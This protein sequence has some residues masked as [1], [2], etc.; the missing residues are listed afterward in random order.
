MAV[1]STVEARYV[2][3]TSAYVRGLQQ[4]TQAT[5]KLASEIPKIEKAN[6]GATVSGLALGAAIGTLGAQV[7]AKATGA[8]MKYAQQGIAAAKQYEQTVISIEGIFAGTGMAMEEAATK[9]QSYLGELRDF[10]AKTPFE[11]PQ[12]LDAVKRLLSIG[13]AADDVKDRMLPAI[14]DIVAALGQPPSAISQIVYAFGQMKSAGRVMSQDL[15]QLGTALPGFNAKMALATEL[16]DGDMQALTKA[17]ESGALDSGKAIDTLITAMTKFGGAAGAMDRQSKT[18][19][20]TLSTFNDT[21]NNALIDGLMPSLPVLSETL[22]QVM[23]AVESV[24]K[25]FAQALGPALIDGADVIG[26]LAPTI[27]ALIPPVIDLASQLVVFS[28]V[29]VTLSPVL[30]VVGGVI[31]S[32]ANALKML[33]SPIF[34]GIAAVLAFRVVMKKLQ[35][36]SGVA[37]TGVGMAFLRIKAAAISTTDTVRLSFMIAGVSLKAFALGAKTLAV[38]FVASMRALGAAAKG[39]MASLGPVGLALVGVTVAMEVFM[40]AGEDTTHIVDALKESVDET[41]GAFGRMSA[42]VASETFRVNLTPEGMK[43]LSEAGLS[44]AQVSA[45]ALAGGDAAEQMRIKLQGLSLTKAALVDFATTFETVANSAVDAQKQVAIELAATADATV[46]AAE[47]SAAAG[48]VTQFQNKVTAQSTVT[49]RNKMTAAERAH[50][51]FVI[52]AENAMSQARMAGK[53]AIEAVTAATE[54][55]SKALEAEATYDNARKGINDLN[56]EL[57]EGKK[58]IKGYSD[59]A[60]NNRSAIRDAAQGYIDYAKGLQDPIEKQNAL[61]EGQKRIRK[62]LK[63]AGIDPKDSDIFQTLKEQSEQSGRTVDEFAGQRLVATQYGNDVGI[64]FIDGIIKELE[65]GKDSVLAGGAAVGAAMVAGTN[66]AAGIQSPSKEAIKTAKF[67]IDGL[68]I[69]LNKGKNSV[70]GTAATVGSSLVDGIKNALSSGSDISSVL[71]NVFGSMPSMPTPLESALGKDGAEKFLKKHEKELLVLQSAFADVDVI[72]NTIRGAND[73]LSEVGAASK[74]MSGTYEGQIVSAPSEIMKS[75]GSDGDLS[76]AISML[77]QLSASANT[78]LDALISISSGKKKKQLKGRK[79]DLRGYLGGMKDEIAGYM[80]RRDQITSELDALE[81]SYGK[82]IDDINE[83]YDRLDEAADLAVSSIESKWDGIIPG[84]K[85]ALDAANQAFDKEN[86][87]LEK[88]ISE[89]DSFLDRVGDGFRSF[90]NELS[91]SKKSIR[92]IVK[93]I[94]GGATITTEEEVVDSGSFRESLE[95]RLATVKEFTSNIKNLLARG[96]DPKLIQD[97]ISAGVGSAGGTVASL[98]SGSSED[99]AAIN[100]LQSS[101]ASE[102]SS[103]QQTA[104][105]QYF[106][107]GIAQQEAVVGPLRAAAANAQAALTLAEESRTIE[108]NAALAHQKKMKDDRDTA[109]ATENAAYKAQKGVLEAEAIAIDA[110]LSKRAAAVQKYFTDLMDPET[111]VPADMFKLGKQAVNGIIKGMKDKEDNL[112]NYATELGN[113]IKNSLAAAL[114]VSSPSRVT[115]T[116]GEQIA[117]GLV[118]GMKSSEDS[119]ARAADSLAGQVVLPLQTPN[120]SGVS[121]APSLSMG[122]GSGGGS[123]AVTNIEINVNAGM[124]ADGD[125]VGEQIV[126]A[127]RKYQRRNGALPLTVQ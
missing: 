20:G 15:M 10:A 48:A 49:A 42:S 97:F 94:G 32:V 81:T 68:N 30:E 57:A 67:F 78:A 61:E 44:V 77:D 18:L 126:S 101:L 96:L 113:I 75:L 119:V 7:F 4:A 59:E 19:A 98:A 8:V 103:F 3:D 22:N 36:E 99:I 120:F 80:I 95:S 43:D 12:T 39:M 6:A 47:M 26:K 104:S 100:A 27:A 60:L 106:D 33:P 35:I 115:R 117:Q 11:L 112:K 93:D 45:A 127:L 62:A 21:V 14:G 69:G 108:L 38:S 53:R 25:A 58:N 107:L 72:L 87:V 111:G 41:T 2:A 121:A 66:E 123:S 9:T 71:S 1:V 46:V 5:N 28:D 89:R 55:L 73:A 76:S 125:Q 34:A 37:A 70:S 54:N 92:K 116:I 51:D 16:F 17:T 85:S 13:Y 110:E 56:K 114:Q 29:I 88:L 24:A 90:A 31:G 83:H 63:K 105:A 118:D 109:I 79:N 91:N 65:A 84:L 102:I 40:G 50:S 122:V 124:G 52:S 74:Q 82:K 86:A 23:P 64:N